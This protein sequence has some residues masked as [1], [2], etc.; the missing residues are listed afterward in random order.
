MKNRNTLACL[1]VPLLGL[2]LS[3][4]SS[5]AAETKISGTISTT[6]TIT[7]DSEL[8]GDVT[9]KVVG[10][11]CIASGAP[12]ITLRLNGF[13][14]TGTIPSCTPATSSNDGIDVLTNDVTILGPGLIQKFG[15]FGILLF[16]ESGATVRG[17]TVTDSCFSGIILAGATDSDIE[18]N[19]SVRN[20]MGSEGA[21]CGGT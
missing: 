6:V 11:P 16:S 17:I 3:A 19:T 21:P 15:G 18:G 20:A 4:G 7:Q 13:R 1:A 14:M 5:Q 10:G 8:V 12:N 2:I 9:C